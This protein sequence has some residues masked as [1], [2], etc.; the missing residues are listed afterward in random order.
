MLICR[1]AI[2]LHNPYLDF[3]D[4]QSLSTTRCLNAARA[5]LTQHYT[6]TATSFDITRLHPLATVSTVHC[7]PAKSTSCRSV[8]ADVIGCLCLDMLVPRRCGADSAV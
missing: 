1:A 5:I 6:L 8:F 7:I 3:T 2:T 4:P